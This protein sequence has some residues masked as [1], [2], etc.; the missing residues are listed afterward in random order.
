MKYALVTTRGGCAPAPAQLAPILQ[1]I[2]SRIGCTYNSLY[3]GVDERRDL[4]RCGKHDQ[5]WLWDTLGPGVANRPG[6]STHELRND[7]VAYAGPATMPL[8]WW[9]CGIDVDDG[10]VQA[11]IRE[12]A[13]EGFTASITYPG[14]RVEYHHVN[15]R[16]E[17]LLDL[18][19]LLRKGDAGPRVVYYSRILARLKRLDHGRFH[20]D[21]L[22]E[23][24]V[25]AF[26]HHWKQK[27]D[28]I[29]GR[30]TARQLKVRYRA[31]K[32]GHPGDTLKS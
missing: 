30:Q 4:E 15:F 8:P 10:H 25:R 26:Q 5:Q 6:R 22:M 18:F 20:F 16:K 31:Y 7:G 32:K 14:S 27:E 19:P 1:R 17:P 21:A 24:A 11:F 12:A 13:R 9:C 29:I 2:A 23:D 28:G 3:R